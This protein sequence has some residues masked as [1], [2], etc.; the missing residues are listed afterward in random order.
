MSDLL[1]YAEFV[2]I[3]KIFLDGYEKNGT[4]RKRR[5][6]TNINQ[7]LTGQYLEQI[8]IL[9]EYIFTVTSTHNP[10]NEL[11]NMYLG[12]YTKTSIATALAKYIDGDAYYNYILYNDVT[13]D[14]VDNY[15]DHED[16]SSLL[17]LCMDCYNNGKKILTRG[18]QNLVGDQLIPEISSKVKH[19]FLEDDPVIY[20]IVEDMKDKR[21]TLYYIIQNFFETSQIPIQIQSTNTIKILNVMKDIEENLM[22]AEFRK[23]IKVKE[24]SSM[25]EKIMKLI[26]ED[27]AKQVGNLFEREKALFPYLPKGKIDLY[28]MYQQ[29]VFN[30]LFRRSSLNDTHKLV[31][32]PEGDTEVVKFVNKCKDKYGE[33]MKE[34]IEL[35]RS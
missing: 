35:F 17:K 28:D 20:M 12:F 7:Y 2:T 24:A 5:G 25:G 31:K 29:E 3:G 10:A 15:I 23:S 27:Y 6:I 9:N 13:D 16:K 8:R 1:T 30:N 22:I 21:R 34:K 33:K 4:I 32:K 18:Y 19:L 26:E 11:E 14:L